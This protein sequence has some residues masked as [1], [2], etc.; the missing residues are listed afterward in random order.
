MDI[1]E[2]IANVLVEQLGCSPEEVRP[3]ASIVGDLYADSLD[4]VELIMALEEEFDIDIDDDSFF[5]LK[6]VGDLAG[7][8]RGRT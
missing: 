6:T 2:R 7:Y 5:A 4:C 1:E 8:V 3:E